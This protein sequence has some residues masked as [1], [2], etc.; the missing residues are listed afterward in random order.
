MAP[1][2]IWPETASTRSRIARGSG[3]TCR[4]IWSY[5][6][7]H[8]RATPA[9]TRRRARLTAPGLFVV[10]DA[11]GYV[12]P[13]TG[14]GMAWALASGAVVAPWASLAVEGWHPQLAAGWEAVYR[15]KVRRRQWPCRGVSFVLRRPKL[16]ALTV[17]ALA[18]APALARPAVARLVS[19]PEFI[20]AA[21]FTKPA[22]P[23]ASDPRIPDQPSPESVP[24]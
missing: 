6:S 11:A 3:K 20:P 23:Q 4:T 14:E 21:A 2:R 5:I 1:L 22:E 16:T 12:E 17:R 9:L 24:A 19:A 15:R 13:F 18:A 10:G 8:W 7:R